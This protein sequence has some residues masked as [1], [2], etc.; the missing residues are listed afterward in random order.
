MSTKIGLQ[1]IKSDYEQMC[2]P[3]IVNNALPIDF[4]SD[5]AISILTSIKT[6]AIF[7]EG[8]MRI[9]LLVLI[10]AT[11][12]SGQ[13]ATYQFS[14]NNYS[15]YYSG[16]IVLDNGGTVQP[17]KQGFVV[18]DSS[19]LLYK[20]VVMEEENQFPERINS[21][22]KSNDGGYYFLFNTTLIKYDESANQINS[23]Q[24]DISGT[25]TNIASDDN[26]NIYLL[27]QASNARIHKITPDY[28][29]DWK[30]TIFPALDSIHYDTYIHVTDGNVICGAPSIATRIIDVNG[31]IFWNQNFNFTDAKIKDDFVYG[32]SN[33]ELWKLGINN[34]TTEK[35]FE[36]L[37]FSC[38]DILDDSI[39]IYQSYPFRRR[40]FLL[41]S[42]GNLLK[43]AKTDLQKVK[44]III[45]QNK[46]YGA[47]PAQYR[48]KLDES[49]T[50]NSLE[51]TNNFNQIFYEAARNLRLYWE[52]ESIEM[53][54]IYFSTDEKNTWQLIA[55]NLP[56][57][58]IW[59][60]NYLW[61][62]PA[63]NME[64][65]FFKI[66]SVDGS[67]FDISENPINVAIYRSADY[68][69]ENNI[70]MWVNNNGSGSQNSIDGGPG[71]YYPANSQN[72]AV[73][74]D[75]P[76]FGYKKDDIP[77]AQGAHYRGGLQPG[78]I[79]YD[80]SVADSADTKYSIYNVRK[81]WQ[82]LPDG[83]NK[84]LLEYFWN[85][86]PVDNGAPWVDNNS[87][88]IYDPTIDSP[89]IPGDQ[90]LWWINN[91]ASEFLSDYLFG[92]QPEKLEI[93]TFVYDLNDHETL[94]ENVV[95]KEY[96]WIN[97]SDETLTDMYFGYWADVDL[98]NANDDVV[99]CNPELNIGYIFN[100][101][102]ND[103]GFYENTPPAIGYQ[104]LNGPSVSGAMYDTAK[105]RN[106]AIVG[107]QNMP[108]TSFIPV[109]KHDYD[110]GDIYV[111]QYEGTLNIYNN[112]QGKTRN[113]DEVVNPLTNEITKFPFDGNPLTHS[114]WY[115]TTSIPPGA[116]PYD[117]RLL[118]SSGP[119]IMEP[120]DTQKVTI[121]I[122]VGAGTDRL[123]SV[124]KLFEKAE[125]LQNYNKYGIERTLNDPYNL[126]IPEQFKL[127][128]NY[129]NPFNPA[130]TI[131]FD[132]PED[133]HVKLEVYN[134]LGERV[135]TLVDEELFKGKH[136]TKF[137]ATG[138]SSGIYIYKIQ[139]DNFTSVKKMVLVK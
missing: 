81:D 38:F 37:E 103:D 68:I 106:S 89:D 115:D 26:A 22:T 111:W 99:G 36:G 70:K 57:N 16:F 73:F 25:I 109:I 29:L 14:H 30:T 102:D 66:E 62:L 46:Y 97:K 119:F 20:K 138:L 5:T 49:L 58:I 56:G 53:V 17:F 93:H 92:S 10:F 94:F 45:S 8:N 63:E 128:N 86:W 3:K 41:N 9:N 27:E 114:G 87:D 15:D 28:S 79:F 90:A 60:K 7:I 4:N 64:S 83:D 54:N 31:E 74:F 33:K 35:L 110:F 43:E 34:S 65:I 125:A 23:H 135:R 42:D 112:L 75:G 44:S 91:S 122:I 32:I 47:G 117:R 2:C 19:G 121:A 39:F 98:G 78:E 77:S 59:E 107:K 134:I 118:V 24:L 130:T 85:N 55:E 1:H 133:S 101:D 50:F 104:I 113:G 120:G 61:R 76:I 136:F 116:P 11:F 51:F 100:G 132:L 139:A 52:T 131:R 80:G 84:T 48:V 127:Y 69:N 129:P 13:N 105:Y 82:D 95:F 18:Y 108:M 6:G 71:F 72:T 40:V 21:L 126:A 123:N 67:Q 124:Q 96:T 12:L 137:E 88:G